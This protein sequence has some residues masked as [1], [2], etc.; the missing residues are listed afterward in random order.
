M[1]LSPNTPVVVSTVLLLGTS[2]FWLWHSPSPQIHLIL[3]FID[4]AVLGGLGGAY[5]MLRSKRKSRE[6]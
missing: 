6:K 4:G 5:V 3:G 2:V 1:R